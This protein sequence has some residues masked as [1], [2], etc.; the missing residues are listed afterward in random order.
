M[1]KKDLEAL[2]EEFVFYSAS[3]VVLVS[4]SILLAAMIIISFSC[5]LYYFEVLSHS[6]MFSFGTHHLFVRDRTGLIIPTLQIRKPTPR[7]G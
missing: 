2:G 1:E 4:P 3:I 6:L 7:K 5:A